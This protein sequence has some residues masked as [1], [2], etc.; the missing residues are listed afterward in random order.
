[1]KLFHK[2]KEKDSDGTSCSKYDQQRIEKVR[3]GRVLFP[4][5]KTSGWIEIISINKTPQ[6]T[7]PFK[8][9]L[10]IFKNV[11]PNTQE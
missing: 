8:Y 3:S 7:K 9:H 11:T 4:L 1:M 5:I 10:T 6:K 2:I